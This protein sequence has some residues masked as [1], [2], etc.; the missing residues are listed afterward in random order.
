MI[1]NRDKKLLKEFGDNLKRIR[2]SKKLSIRKLALEADIDYTGL[3][4]IEAGVTNLTYTT[5]IAL[6]VALEIDPADLLPRN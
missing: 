2:K 5:L 1:G 4:K 6:A 3:F